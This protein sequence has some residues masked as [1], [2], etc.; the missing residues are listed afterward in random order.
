M[1]FAKNITT[2][3]QV[4]HGGLYSIGNPGSKVIDFSSNVNPLGYPASLKLLKN[5]MAKIPVYPDHASLRLKE[6]LAKHLGVQIGSIVVGNGATEVI[7]NFCRAT[8]GKKIQV[9]I[10]VP[11]FGEYEAAA[12]LCNGKLQFFKTMNLENDLPKF[13]KKIPKKGIVFVCNPNNPTGVL[14]PK[15]SM[16]K[17]LKTA[18]KR[19]TLV[20]VDECFMELTQDAR[21]SVIDQI[22][23]FENLFVLG[24]LTKSFGLAGLRIGYGIGNKKLVSVLNKIKIPWSVSGVAQEAAV[25]ALSDANFLAKTRKMLKIESAFLR[26]S[27]SK[28]DGFS[29]FDTSANFILIK[30]KTSSKI[31]QKKLV[32]KRILIRDCSTFRGL[33]KNYVRI[34][35]RTRNEN[36][37]L[38]KA[39]EVLA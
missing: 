25:L 14:I 34:A 11:T 24:S 7:Y 39:L 26:N 31:L 10:P 23:K 33:G 16:L 27:I 4:P 32:Q 9:L 37:K 8:I 38:I 15:D 30:T 1:K 28:L 21:Q 5:W 19:G 20:F 29:C 17:I 12:R 18:K 6:Q 13:V 2:H 22:S 3:T 36:V 35:I